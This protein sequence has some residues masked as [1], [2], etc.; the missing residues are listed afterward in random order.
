MQVINPSK[1]MDDLLDAFFNKIDTWVVHSGFVEHDLDK[2]EISE[3]L[4]RGPE[5]II[6]RS[7][8]DLLL[9]TFSLY[10]YLDLLQAE[11]NHQRMVLEYAESSIL[12]LI[13]GVLNK[14]GDQYTKYDVR[15]NMAVRAD[16]MCSELMKL[17]L[18]SKARITESDGRIYNVKKMTEILEQLAKKKMYMERVN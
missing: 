14:F 16:P 15:Y 17:V 2:D 18:V 13:S 7:S 4:G 12:N 1:D 10:R 9:D 11:C 8:E 5:E 3:I 6:G